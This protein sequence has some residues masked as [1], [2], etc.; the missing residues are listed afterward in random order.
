MCVDVCVGARTVEQ[1]SPYWAIPGPAIGLIPMRSP[2]F[3]VNEDL[4]H[5]EAASAFS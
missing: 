5:G 2:E 3:T 4:D 1:D